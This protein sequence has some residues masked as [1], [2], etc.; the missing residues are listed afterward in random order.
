MRAVHRWG[1]NGVE[2][3]G[4]AI[5]RGAK[6]ARWVLG[7]F[8]AERR[9]LFGQSMGGL[10]AVLAAQTANPSVDRLMLY[11]PMEMRALDP[12]A[13]ADVR[14]RGWDRALGRASTASSGTYDYVPG[15]VTLTPACY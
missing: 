7:A 13:D 10:T 8:G 5:E 14:E 4:P 15:F 11:E 12:D 1:G 3:A 9:A 6:V 2:E